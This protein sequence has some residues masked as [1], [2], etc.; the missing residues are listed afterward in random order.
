MIPVGKQQFQISII[1]PSYNRSL[2]TAEAVESVLSQ[3]LADIEIIVVDDGSTDD[4]SV[5][6]SPFAKQK[7]IKY[8]YQKNGGE[9]AARNR[10][11]QEAHGKYIAFLDSDDLLTPNSLILRLD[12]LDSHSNIGLVHGNFSKFSE[13][14]PDLG[15]RDTSWFQ[16][17]IYPAILC[18]WSSLIQPSTVMIPSRVF[19]NIGLFTPGLSWGADIDLWFRIARQYKFAHIPS[20]LA[21]V[22]VHPGNISGNRKDEANAFRIIL[23][24]AFSE[25][26][27]LSDRVHK[28]AF[29]EMYTVTGLNLLGDYGQDMMPEARSRLSQGIIYSQWNLRPYFGYFLSYWPQ[30][31]RHWLANLWRRSQYFSHIKRGMK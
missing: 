28:K 11:I 20:T 15:T 12:Y 18:H 4:T 10:G 1:I 23:E 21:R 29:G 31:I 22:R 9:S 14:T 7:I 5:I 6:L 3:Q 19:K 25:D 13:D 17:D 2:L 26:A 27:A 16:G 24:K 8:I 30:G